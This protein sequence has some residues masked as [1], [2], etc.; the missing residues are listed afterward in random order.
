MELVH[1]SSQPCEANRLF[2]M[3]NYSAG[4]FDPDDSK[5]NKGNFQLFGS[6]VAKQP[7]G[8]ASSS[9]DEGIS[10]SALSNCISIIESR[11][12]TRD[13]ITSIRQVVTRM[14][15]F[16]SYQAAAAMSPGIVLALEN[17][18]ERMWAAEFDR[19]ISDGTPYPTT[20]RS[21]WKYEKD[22]KLPRTKKA[23]S[24]QRKTTHQRT[25]S[26]PQPDN[27]PTESKT[28]TAID[29]EAKSPTWSEA[30]SQPVRSYL[31]MHGP[32][33]TIAT[34]KKLKSKW[35]R[36][37]SPSPR[38]IE[39][40]LHGAGDLTQD[41][42]DDMNEYGPSLSAIRR[43]FP[44]RNLSSS[45]PKL[46]LSV[47]GSL[48]PIH[49][50]SYLPKEE[51]PCNAPISV[52]G[53]SV[54]VRPSRPSS[55]KACEGGKWKDANKRQ[56][57]QEEVLKAASYVS[58]VRLPPCGVASQEV[59]DPQAEDTNENTLTAESLPDERYQ[60]K[61]TATGQNSSTS[62]S[63]LGIRRSPPDRGALVGFPVR[64]HKKGAEF[65]NVYGLRRVEEPVPDAKLLVGTRE[66][67]ENLHGN[68]VSL[69]ESGNPRRKGR[70][71]AKQRRNRANRYARAS[72]NEQ[73][74]ALEP[75]PKTSMGS[76]A[77]ANGGGPVSSSRRPRSRR[78]RRQS[79]HGGAS[80]GR[81]T[82]KTANRSRA[83]PGGS[84]PQSRNELA[85][86]SDFGE[87]NMKLHPM[88][89]GDRDVDCPEK[90]KAR[91]LRIKCP[92]VCERTAPRSSKHGGRA[93]SDV[94]TDAEKS[95]NTMRSASWIPLIGANA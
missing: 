78:E 6:G 58:S 56:G 31:Q 87:R 88:D 55:A 4:S 95:A 44:Q 30:P 29:I 28:E 1:M 11:R 71:K 34:E 16:A 76:Q 84:Y 80:L 14:V 52:V 13:D 26:A 54:C 20:P 70:R 15:E 57:V 63:P 42:S 65:F 93:P 94:D 46:E 50:D 72:Q 17:Y 48:K 5:E 38:P 18:Q 21:P 81:A 49:V 73:Y 53:G 25:R 60:N 90:D 39:V 86:D 32:P 24:K 82:D 7:E 47:M 12:L 74:L 43:P 77:K 62:L 51:P 41:S 92:V 85:E 75:I 37:G 91:E 35:T 8:G 69:S 19:M 3:T 27:P 36:S 10:A 79:A 59:H 23:P 9:D 33:N 89:A 2:F 66:D 45:T 40:T 64:P 83:S 22:T 67:A 61:T 68:P